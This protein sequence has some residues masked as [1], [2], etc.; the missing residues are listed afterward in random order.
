MEKIKILCSKH[1]LV[2][3]DKEREDGALLVVAG[4]NE[5]FIATMS[6]VNHEPVRYEFASMRSGCDAIDD[7]FAAMFPNHVCGEGC[8]SWR[9]M[10]ADNGT[11]T[12]Q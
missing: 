1:I 5:K 7:R 3:G 6:S 9:K 4:A 8:R 11:S 2:T 10:S 12:L